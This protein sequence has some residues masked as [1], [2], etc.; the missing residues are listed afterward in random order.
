M[1]PQFWKQCLIFHVLVSG[2][3]DWRPILALYRS[4]H[5]VFFNQLSSFCRTTTLS[6]DRFTGAPGPASLP[7]QMNLIICFQINISL[8]FPLLLI[9]FCSYSEPNKNNTYSFETLSIKDKLRE[10]SD[11]TLYQVQ[12]SFLI[13]QITSIIIAI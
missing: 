1:I 10:L 5:F 3:P 13:M 2:S 4:F 9:V 8:S 6:L 12:N 11:L 7:V